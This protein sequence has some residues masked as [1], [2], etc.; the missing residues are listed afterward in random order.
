MMKVKVQVAKK[1]KV[2]KETMIPVGNTGGEKEGNA[3]V[4]RSY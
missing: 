4:G 3:P 2:A 1:E